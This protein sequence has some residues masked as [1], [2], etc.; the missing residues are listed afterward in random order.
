MDAGEVAIIEV[1]LSDLPIKRDLWQHLQQDEVADD[2]AAGSVVENGGRRDGGRMG[3][4][5]SGD[6]DSRN[7]R[8]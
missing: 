5:S 6:Q 7:Q 8:T 4:A 3:A 2:E 1:Y